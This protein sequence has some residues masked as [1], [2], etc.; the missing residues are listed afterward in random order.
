MK[1]RLGPVFFRFRMEPEPQPV[2]LHSKV[3]YN[4][5][6]LH[7]VDYMQF[8]PTRPPVMVG[9]TTTGCRLTRVGLNRYYL[10]NYILTNNIL[11]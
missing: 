3:K 6:E 2:Q 5:T 1:V 7:V 4:R 8:G 11:K 10:H 9:S